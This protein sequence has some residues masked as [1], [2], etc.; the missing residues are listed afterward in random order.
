MTPKELEYALDGFTG[1]EQ[2]HRLPYP[3]GNLLMTDGVNYLVE[4]AKCFWLMDIIASYQ[5]KLKKEDFQTWTLTH[6]KPA[7]TAPDMWTVGAVLQSKVGQKPKAEW[8]VTC[9]D[10]DYNLL[11]SQDIEYSDFPLDSIKL[12]A[13]RSEY[14]EGLVVMLTGE[15]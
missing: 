4:E 13:V 11:V 2:Y 12:F 6:N 3:T 14:P 8:Q 9:G 10:G 5:R 15:Y 1:T 7:E